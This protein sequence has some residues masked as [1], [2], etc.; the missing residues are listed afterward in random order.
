MVAKAMTG[1]Q[2]SASYIG[3]AGQ[4]VAHAKKRG[5]GLVSR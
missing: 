4:V 5:R 3:V 2:G 1:R